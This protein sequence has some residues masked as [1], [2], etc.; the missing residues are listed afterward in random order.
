MLVMT[1]NRLQGVYISCKAS[2]LTRAVFAILIEESMTAPPG[3]EPKSRSYSL[4]HAHLCSETIK[5]SGECAF[6]NV[7]VLIQLTAAKGKWYTSIVIDVYQLKGHV[8]LLLP[9]L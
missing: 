3:S 7:L 5:P 1:D 2:S 8:W 4:S 9:K 6:A